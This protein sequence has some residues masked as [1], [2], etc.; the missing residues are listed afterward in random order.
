MADLTKYNPTVA[1]RTVLTDV[2]QLTRA[3]VDD[4]ATFRMTVV[5]ADTNNAGYGQKEV[6]MYL[7]DYTGT[8]YRIIATSGNTIDVSDDFRSNPNKCPMSGHTAIVHKSAYKGQSV[9]LPADLIRHLHPIAPGNIMRYSMSIL[10][11]NDP[12]PVRISFTNSDSP[13]IFNYR[14]NQVNEFGKTVN[15]AEDYGENP[16][17]RLIQLIDGTAVHR[18]ELPVYTLDAGLITGIGFGILDNEITG[19]IEISR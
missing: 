16:K 12:N 8:P 19:Y 15:Y 2:F 5:P 17:V 10:W 18:T 9:A 11:N 13:T 4:P 1:W 6:G 7:T 3:N 14:T